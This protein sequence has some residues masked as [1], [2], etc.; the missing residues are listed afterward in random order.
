MEEGLTKENDVLASLNNELDRLRGER[1]GEEK[2]A[3]QT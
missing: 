1:E 3:G 2:E